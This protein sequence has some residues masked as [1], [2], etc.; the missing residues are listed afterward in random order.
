MREIRYTGV[1]VFNGRYKTQINRK[2]RPFYLG[3]YDL[4]TTA[5]EY[6]DR[7]LILTHPWS[8][9][10]L[11]LN[12]LHSQ[13]PVPSEFTSWEKDMI[14]WLRSHYPTQEKL[15][16]EEQT[17]EYRLDPVT[18]RFAEFLL[19]HTEMS[20]LSTEII[21]QAHEALKSAKKREI[22]MEQRIEFNAEEIKEL[23]EELRILKGKEKLVAPPGGWFRPVKPKE[24][25]PAV[26]EPAPA[27]VEPPPEATAAPA[28]PEPPPEAVSVPEPVSAPTETAP[29]LQLEMVPEK[30]P[31]IVTPQFGQS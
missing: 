27:A 24:D 23:R 19:A 1:T 11:R 30:T 29:A 17:V 8:N 9:R 31:E 26:V 6:A 2:G 20:R 7:A 15:S 13:A 21:P 10:P 18:K 16:K 5:A 28:V 22:E 25:S 12:F 14:D 4:A 3:S